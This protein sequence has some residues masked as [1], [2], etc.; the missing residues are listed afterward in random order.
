[1]DAF[2][3][4]GRIRLSET[5]LDEV[6]L[7][8][9]TL[10]REAIGGVDAAS[11]TLVGAR[12]SG[13]AACTGDLA[14]VLDEWQYE[15]EGGPCLEAAAT[16]TVVSV[17]DTTTEE[18]WPA[19]LK[20]ATAAGARSI[21]SVGLPVQEVVTGALNLYSLEPA[22]FDAE[23]IAVAQEFAGFAAVALANAQS[24]DETAALARQMREAMAQRATIEQAKGII[25]AEQRCTPDEA[26]ERLSKL[27]QHA[28][29]KLRDVAA[30][31]V[32]RAS[33]PR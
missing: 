16:T 1:M 22:A 6:L 28:N 20:R 32:A 4:L 19:Y 10:A 17:P 23:A 3:E 2:E 12:R 11:V 25:M 27:S 33:R 31:L 21:L 13:S 30:A 26:F 8:V 14:K 18:R 29:R 15:N 24:Y 5:S 7:R 9:A